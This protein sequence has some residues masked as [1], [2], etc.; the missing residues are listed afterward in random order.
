MISRDSRQFILPVS[1]PNYEA[2]GIE[3]IFT[4]SDVEREIYYAGV[5]TGEGPWSNIPD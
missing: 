3:M 2:P 1:V 4:S 5:F